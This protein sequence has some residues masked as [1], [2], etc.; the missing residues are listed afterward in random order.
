M[1]FIS[2]YLNAKKKSAFPVQF[3][4]SPR[5]TGKPSNK[6]LPSRCDESFLNQLTDNQ[7]HCRSGQTE[8]TCYLSSGK[9]SLFF[10]EPQNACL[11]Y[12]AEKSRSRHRPF[13]KRFRICKQRKSSLSLLNSP[14]KV[15]LRGNKPGKQLFT[16]ARSS[17]R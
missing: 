5:S 17:E 11:I 14:G 12:V 4:G 13:R 10:Q 6:C 8:I 3:Q 9:Y 16:V 7:S 15:F 1:D 2:T